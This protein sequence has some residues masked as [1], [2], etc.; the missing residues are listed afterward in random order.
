MRIFLNLNNPVIWTDAHR[1]VSSMTSDREYSFSLLH[2]ARNRFWMILDNT[3]WPALTRPKYSPDAMDA[4]PDDIHKAVSSV[5]APPWSEKSARMRI[6]CL[7]VT[8]LMQQNSMRCDDA[9]W[10]LSVEPAEEKAR[11][12]PIGGKSSHCMQKLSTPSHS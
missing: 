9:F 8:F 10:S 7:V 2:R 12:I 6:G 3:A 1:C 11:A 5:T 4:E